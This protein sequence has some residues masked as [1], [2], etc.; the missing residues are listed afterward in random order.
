[1]KQIGERTGT[2]YSRRTINR[3]LA[4]LGA[5]YEHLF[6]KGHVRENP[7]R[8][9]FEVIDVRTGALHFLLWTSGPI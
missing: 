6:I 5:F 3:K 9:L 4:C 7:T 8:R 2:S 1:M